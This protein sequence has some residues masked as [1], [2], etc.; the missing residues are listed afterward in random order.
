M[1]VFCFPTASVH[2]NKYPLYL[3]YMN[4]TTQLVLQIA[5]P[6]MIVYSISLLLH[7]Q[8]YIEMVKQFKEN[9]FFIILAAFSNLVL[10]P[11]IIWN[12][13]LWGTLPEVVVTLI[14]ILATAKGLHIALAPDSWVKMANGF[15]SKTILKTAPII[16]FLIGIWMLY[17]SFP[18]SS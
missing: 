8:F 4:H 2:H 12:H 1:V 10:G 14:G 5:G 16:M 11:A 6:I 17:I 9:N 7:R 13:W 15:T 18:L 3:T